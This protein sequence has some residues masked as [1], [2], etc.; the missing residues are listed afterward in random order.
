MAADWLAD[1]VIYEI[2]PQSFADSDGDG[3]GDLR[4]VIDRL[5]HIASLGVDTVWFNPCFASPFVDAGYDVSDYLT[6]RAPLRHQR[7]PR[8]AGGRGPRARHPR[9]ARPGGRA[10]LD[11]APVVPARA[12]RRRSRPR[13]RPLHLVRGAAGVDVARG[14]ARHARLGALAGPAAGL[15]P[16]ELLRRAARAEL[17]LDAGARRRALAR[18]RR[19]PRPAA[20][21]ADAAGRDR[22]LAQPRASPA[23]GST[24]P[25]R[26]SRT[27]GT[28]RPG[29]ARRPRCGARSGRGST[30]P[31]PT[32]C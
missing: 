31:T 11:R 23:S 7:R 17:R 22:L 25:S 21:P 10:H 19:R 32:P 24:W 12:A 15:V 14:P 18:R 6:D 16:A 8:R 2:Y 5:D 1:A 4:G 26:W 28:R 3:V 9:A 27:T 20:Q 30:R 13:G 29:R